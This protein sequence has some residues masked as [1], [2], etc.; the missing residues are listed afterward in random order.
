MHFSQ[1]SLTLF[2][3]GG[4]GGLAPHK[5]AVA[6]LL[7][8]PSYKLEASAVFRTQGDHSHQEHYKF[9]YYGFTY[10]W[11]NSGSPVLVG[12]LHSLNVFGALP[13]YT[14]DHPIRFRAGFGLGYLT[15]KFDKLT[16]HKNS[17]IGSH[18]N[19][20]IQ[21]RLEKEF[22]ILNKNTLS[23]GLGISHFSNASVQ[24]PNLGLNFFHLYLNA[25]FQV[26]KY[27]KL[28]TDG[29][30]V[31]DILPYSKWETSILT[32]GGIRENI[33]PLGPKYFVGVITLQQ[34]MRVSEFSSWIGALD[35]YANMSLE[36]KSGKWYQLGVSVAYMKHFNKLRIGLAAGTYILN[37]P[38][39][40]A[41]VYNKVVVEYHFSK[42]FFTQLLLKSHVTTADFFNLTFGYK[43]R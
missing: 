1:K 4:A 22:Q 42:K 43:I 6:H 9:P 14:G 7:N 34:T 27:T 15:R 29:E 40:E 16:N 24:K 21:F 30:K 8:G 28:K 10:A 26:R 35:N 5:A 33:T 32:G 19:V 12:E 17:A 3:G 36:R 23:L 2:L 39:P 38:Y 13:L 31:I 18:F 37:R 20:N 25:G 41:I 11:N